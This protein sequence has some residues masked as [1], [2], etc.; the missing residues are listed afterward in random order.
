M[1]LA[2]IGGAGGTIVSSGITRGANPGFPVEGAAAVITLPFLPG[3]VD[4]DAIPPPVVL[5]YA[6]GISNNAS[7]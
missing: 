5:S 4:F 2:L 6:F 7:C 1:S 3:T